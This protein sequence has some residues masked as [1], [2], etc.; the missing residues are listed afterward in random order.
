LNNSKNVKEIKINSSK[1][2]F[3]AGAYA[4]LPFAGQQKSALPSL[5]VCH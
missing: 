3:K 4:D 5:T 1:F 2:I